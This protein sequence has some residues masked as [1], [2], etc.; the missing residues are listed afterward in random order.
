MI[1]IE[2][3]QCAA[4]VTEGDPDTRDVT[5]RHWTTGF[6]KKPVAGPVELTRLGIVGDRVA[7]TRNHGGPDKA[8]LCYASKHYRDWANEFPAL[9]MSAGGLAE[10]LTLS[11][12]D[13][14]TCCIGDRYSICEC[15]IEVS[16]PRQPCWKIAR[17]WGEKSLTKRVA[18]TGRTGW[19]VRVVRVGLISP[20]DEM[21]LTARPNPTWTVARANAVMLDRKSDPAAVSESISLTEL[22]QEW[23]N[24]LGSAQ[25]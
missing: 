14:T 7:D 5:S 10:N 19:Y 8:V 4:I 12:I 11:G 17:R 21:T 2:S 16:Q 9:G 6:Y 24:D 23:K 18:Q 1:V 20:A 3:I 22:S 13:E 25:D 15:E